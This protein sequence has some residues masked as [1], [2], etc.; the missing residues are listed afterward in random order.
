MGGFVFVLCFGVV[1]K[2]V[3]VYEEIKLVVVGFKIDV[4]SSGGVDFIGC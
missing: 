1:F 4:V 2:F 3:G